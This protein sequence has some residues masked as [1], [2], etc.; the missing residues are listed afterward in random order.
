M[1]Y[2]WNDDKARINLDKHGVAFADAVCVFEDER[3]LSMADERT[4]WEQRF[5]SLGMDMMG[6]ILTVVYTYRDEGTIRVISARKATPRE[7]QVYA[8]T[9]KK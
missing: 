3:C 5:V 6:N 9:Y 1:E 4:D 2:E 8:E 7:R